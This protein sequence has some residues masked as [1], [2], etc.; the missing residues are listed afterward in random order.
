MEAKKDINNIEKV[1]Y[2]LIRS[3]IET[4]KKEIFQTVDIMKKSIN[5]DIKNNDDIIINK[6]KEL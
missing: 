6:I 3:Y 1:D 4:N 5:N 2:S